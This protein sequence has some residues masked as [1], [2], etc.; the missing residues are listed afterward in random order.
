MSNLSQLFAIKRP[1]KSA[2]CDRECSRPIIKAVNTRNSDPKTEFFRR[3]RLYFYDTNHFD[4]ANIWGL[5]HR[6]RLRRRESGKFG[7]E[8]Q[9]KRKCGRSTC[10]HGS[11]EYATG[12][13]VR[14]NFAVP[15]F[16]GIG[17]KFHAGAKGISNARY[18]ESRRI[19]AKA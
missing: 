15:G 3:Y 13:F 10:C 11:A 1:K 6:C 8:R 19:K 4:L 7:G 5:C 14:T 9:S 16:A 17:F 12:Y 2:I 18:S